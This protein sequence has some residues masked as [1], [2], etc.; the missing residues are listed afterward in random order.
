MAPFSLQS[1]H[2]A[3]VLLPAPDTALYGALRQWFQRLRIAPTIVGEFDD[4]ALMKVFGQAGVGVFC[5]PS[6]IEREVREQYD[7]EAIGR[8]KEIRER[9]YLI[10][11]ERRLGNPA[12][13][14]VS[15]AAHQIVFRQDYGDSSPSAPSRTSS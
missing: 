11:T 7:V 6:V 1:L 10:S 3:P 8:T 14:A 5:A 9:F 15:R 2:C 13:V 12:V 4:S